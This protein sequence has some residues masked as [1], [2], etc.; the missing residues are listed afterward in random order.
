MGDRD[1]ETKRHLGIYDKTILRGPFR[2]LSQLLVFHNHLGIDG[3]FVSIHSFSHADF[4]QDGSRAGDGR[5]YTS[6][7]IHAGANAHTDDYPN[8]HTG[9]DAHPSA[10]AAGL[11]EAEVH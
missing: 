5:Q 4:C 7:H 3:L 6:T 2:F 8:T 11:L 9:A 1:L 10:A